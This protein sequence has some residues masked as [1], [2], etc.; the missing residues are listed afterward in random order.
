MRVSSI[1]DL[2]VLLDSRLSFVEH[3]QLILSKA[4]KMLG[5]ISRLTIDFK[6]S[7]SILHLYKS[8]VLP[9]LMQGSIIW[10]PHYHLSYTKENA[11]ERANVSERINYIL[12][13]S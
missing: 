9:H 1:S 2:G 13:F 4:L 6:E 12:T 7:D 5:F 11:N 8:F 10:S 3:T